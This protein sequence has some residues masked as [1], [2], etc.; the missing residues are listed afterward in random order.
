MM[1]EFATDRVGFA[2]RHCGHEWAADYELAHY[3]EPDGEVFDYFA[4]DGRRVPSPYAAGSLT[5]CPNCH[6]PT[7][8]GHL[9]TRRVHPDMS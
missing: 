8:F 5:L 4:L 6:E 7:A 3:E 9:V 1:T 2:C